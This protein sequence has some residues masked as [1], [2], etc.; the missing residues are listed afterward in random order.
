MQGNILITGG[1]GT[2]GKAII[3]RSVEEN[4]DCRITIFSTDPV[5]H[6]KV[7]KQYPH[8]NCIVGDIRDA[9]TVFNAMA[10]RDIVI[11]A[12]AV[13]EIPTS[14]WNPIDTFQINVE[15][16]INVC[17]AAISHHI[18]LVIGISTDKACHPANAYG[19]TKYLME[20]SFQEFSRLGLSTRFNLVRYGNVLESSAA[21]IEDWE[22]TVPEGRPIRITDPEM[23]RFWISPSQAVDIVVSSQ[24][25]ESGVI[26]VSKMPS[27]SISKLAEYVLEPGYEVQ[28]IPM[29]AGEKMHETLLTV[30]EGSFAVE[31]DDYFFLRPTT[32]WRNGNGNEYPILP[33][34]SSDIAP[35]LTETEL[36]ELLGN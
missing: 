16:S 23:T 27:L 17:N 21:V 8:I 25:M 24:R 19:A 26:L 2:L 28:R 31:S 7:T 29:R 10:G 15:G 35:E 6:A 1:A 33:P 12:A 14:E 18:P 11:H 9:T 32:S 34:Y 20:K 30:E 5:K 4:W 22:R 3:K 13:K 36:A